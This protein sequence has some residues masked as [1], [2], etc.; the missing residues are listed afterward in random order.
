MSPTWRLAIVRLEV[1]FRDNLPATV[2]FVVATDVVFDPVARLVGLVKPEVITSL[3]I[4]DKSPA[5]QA[6]FLDAVNGLFSEIMNKCSYIGVF[7]PSH[8]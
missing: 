8:V 6:A 2:V 1:T 5:E 7:R 3:R 4:V